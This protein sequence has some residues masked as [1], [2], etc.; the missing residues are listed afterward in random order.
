MMSKKLISLYI[1]KVLEEN[2]LTHEECKERILKIF[3][4]RNKKEYIGYYLDNHHLACSLLRKNNLIK[5]N[6]RNM[7]YSTED[8]K[9]LSKFLSFDEIDTYEKVNNVLKE[10]KPI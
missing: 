4:L 8:G 7:I 10:I 1:L 3:K 5:S 6:N 9:I 2:G